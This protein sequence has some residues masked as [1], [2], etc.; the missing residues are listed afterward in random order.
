MQGNKKSPKMYRLSLFCKKMY[1]TTPKSFDNIRVLKYEKR[2]AFSLDAFLLLCLLVGQRTQHQRAFCRTGHFILQVISYRYL[3]SK[4]IS[5]S[6]DFFAEGR[7]RRSSYGAG[8]TV[9]FY[10]CVL[11]PEFCDSRRFLF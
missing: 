8:G 4:K 6:G 10:I 11:K 9:I 2:P 5:S 1:N 3:L 7:N